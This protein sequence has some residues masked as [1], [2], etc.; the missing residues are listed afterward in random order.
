MVTLWVWCAKGKRN[1]TVSL[2]DRVTE[3][4]CLGAIKT[5]TLTL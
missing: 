2:G 5:L 3:E 1:K 4:C